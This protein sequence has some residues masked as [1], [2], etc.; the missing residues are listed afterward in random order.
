MSD[1]GVPTG[2]S[3]VYSSASL[4]PTDSQGGM[5]V[6]AGS[7]ANTKGTWSQ[8]FS[9]IPF[10]ACG[11]SIVWEYNYNATQLSQFFVDIGIGASGSEVVL[12][13][14]LYF[15]GVIQSLIRCQRRTPFIPLSI[16]AG[17]RIALRAQALVGND[18]LVGNMMLHA[19]AFGT[20]P[21]FRRAASYGAGAN[22]GGVVVTNSSAN[23]AGSWFE[24]TSS[25]T[26]PHKALMVAMGMV[27]AVS[28][29]D[30]CFDIGIGASGSE[31]VLIPGIPNTANT[32]LGFTGSNLYSELFLVNVPAGSRLSART[33][34]AGTG[35]DSQANILIYGFD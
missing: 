1:W 3:T 10:A 29:N 11:F 19:A 5:A 7:T 22:S 4:T 8:V 27:P 28:S 24:V 2:A 23:V 12:L 17:A 6:N 25:T 20:P 13:P 14:D 31:Q 16:P 15:L 34:A 30:C 32:N 26:S 18:L 35:G 33:T 9:S 21:P